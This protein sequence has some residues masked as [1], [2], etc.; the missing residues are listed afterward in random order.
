MHRLYKLFAVCALSNKQDKVLFAILVRAISTH[1]STIVNAGLTVKQSK[2]STYFGDCGQHCL[3]ALK[4]GIW[5]IPA[6][7]K[8]ACVA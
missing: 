1:C 5:G 7:Q 3:I 2:L 4:L 6:V 8:E